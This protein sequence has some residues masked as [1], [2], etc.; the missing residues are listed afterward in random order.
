MTIDFHEF[1]C[2][3]V[4]LSRRYVIR[5]HGFFVESTATTRA[6]TSETPEHCC[7]VSITYNVVT[8]FFPRPPFE[9]LRFAV[10]DKTGPA[11]RH[12]DRLRLLNL[13]KIRLQF[14]GVLSGLA[15]IQKRRQ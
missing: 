15:A 7:P 14:T 1:G 13:M 11:Y 8:P 12:S 4:L 6:I 3:G 2:R 5:T 10:R 9:F